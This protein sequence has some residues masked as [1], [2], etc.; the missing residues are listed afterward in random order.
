MWASLVTEAGDILPIGRAKAEPTDVKDQW[1][2]TWEI[3][4]G[5]IISK[6]AILWARLYIN[7]DDD[8]WFGMKA[9]KKANQKQLKAHDR[10]IMV[11]DIRFKRR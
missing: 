11:W 9:L 5:L 7:K 6:G 8:D 3:P 10:I 1:Q 4:P 2:F